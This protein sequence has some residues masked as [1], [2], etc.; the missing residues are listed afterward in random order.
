[1][2]GVLFRARPGPRPILSWLLGEARSQSKMPFTSV[3]IRSRWAGS[4]S[5]WP[6]TPTT[7][8]GLKE[9]PDVQGLA[10]IIER[11][12]LLQSNCLQ[13]S[14]GTNSIAICFPDFAFGGVLG[15]G[16][17]F[18]HFFSSSSCR[19][20][21]R[22]FFALGFLSMQPCF[23]RRSASVLTTRQ[24][25]NKP[26]P[27]SFATRIVRRLNRPEARKKN[28][29]ST[30]NVTSAQQKSIHGLATRRKKKNASAGNHELASKTWS[31]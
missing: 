8:A 6:V 23:A 2:M 24:I 31:V 21:L 3:L 16:V 22:S 13:C 11:L 7:K 18:D 20:V 27:F 17:I 9:S 1:M 19:V 14:Q 30:I 10:I 4:R 25:A 12:A 29:V 26:C 5:I 28:T 15:R